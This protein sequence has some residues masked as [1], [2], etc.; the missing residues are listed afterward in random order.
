MARRIIAVHA[1]VAVLL[2]SFCVLFFRLWFHAP[3]VV[4]EIPES[5]PIDTVTEPLLA[6]GI[7]TRTLVCILVAYTLISYKPSI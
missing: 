6:N 5:N 1:C 7:V 4:V 2:A 3:P